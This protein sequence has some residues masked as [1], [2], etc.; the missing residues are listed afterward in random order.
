MKNCGR[1]LAGGNYLNVNIYREVGDHLGSIRGPG[2]ERFSGLN[3]G[4]ESLSQNVQQ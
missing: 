4:G 3:G 2:D 1:R